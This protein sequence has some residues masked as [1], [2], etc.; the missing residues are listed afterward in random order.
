MKHIKTAL[1][2]ALSY[3]VML[4]GVTAGPVPQVLTPPKEDAGLFDAGRFNVSPFAAL[5]FT[6]ANKTTG[7]WGGGLALS[8]SPADNIDVEVS[9]ASYSL[10]DS[11]VVESFDEGSVSFKGY[12]PIGQSGLAPYGLIGY[13]RDHPNDQNL[14][15]I[16]AGVELR[17]KHVRAFVEGR[18]ETTLQFQNRD[19]RFQLRIGGGFS[20]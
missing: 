10:T 19:N 18:Y 8:Y 7:K 4:L 14:A 1:L 12:L 16:G 13:T 6:E 17:A 2:I 20:F 5:K 9:A 11:P 15:D 3:I